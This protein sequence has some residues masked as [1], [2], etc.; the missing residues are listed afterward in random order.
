MIAAPLRPIYPAQGTFP[1]AGPGERRSDGACS[2]GHDRAMTT[3][4]L[5]NWSFSAEE[6]SAGVWRVR[7]LDQAGRSV[8][9]TGTDPEATLEKCKS[10][11]REIADDAPRFG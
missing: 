2:V 11:A 6:I 7:G 5:T 3:E 10:S 8:E 1:N 9:A 4:D